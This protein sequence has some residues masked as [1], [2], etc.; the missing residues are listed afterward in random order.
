[1]GNGDAGGL[2]DAAAGQARKNQERE[3]SILF[4]MLLPSQFPMKMS[5]KKPL[6]FDCACGCMAES[7]GF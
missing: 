2:D 1:M 6:D 5:S 3:K 4:L 7:T